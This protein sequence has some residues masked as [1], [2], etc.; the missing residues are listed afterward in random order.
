MNRNSAECYSFE[1]SSSSLQLTDNL[2]EKINKN[3]SYTN[4]VLS[5]YSFTPLFLSVDMMML[6]VKSLFL[7][8]NT[9]HY[10]EDDDNRGFNIKI[11]FNIR[12][13]IYHQLHQ[14]HHLHHQ[15]V[16]ELFSKTDRLVF[17]RILIANDDNDFN[18]D[19]LLFGTNDQN[20][21][22][23]HQYS[24]YMK[25]S[26]ICKLNY[27]ISSSNEN[28]ISTISF[29]LTILSSTL[30][31]TLSVQTIPI[32]DN[33]IFD[34]NNNN[35]NNNNEWSLFQLIILHVNYAYEIVNNCN[36]NSLPISYLDLKR[37]TF[38][39][40]CFM[41]YFDDHYHDYCNYDNIIMITL[42]LESISKILNIDSYHIQ[43]IDSLLNYMINNI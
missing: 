4:H 34:N 13:R 10:N 41:I 30:S 6:Q 17:Q 2:Y 33:N 29:L 31:S 38:Y 36:D 26:Y 21:F 32:D 25:L 20:Q 11:L 35:N 43:F 18:I 28:I 24:K 5:S 12:T 14:H 22:N 42:V 15:Q 1:P 9:C 27:M 23:H 3:N 8:R 40:K 19:Y 39:K 37:Y 7:C 16:M